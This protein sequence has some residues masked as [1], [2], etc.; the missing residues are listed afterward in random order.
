[1]SLCPV[2]R[3]MIGNRMS[4]SIICIITHN[5]DSLEHG[6]FLVFSV[7]LKNARQWGGEIRY[8]EDFASA[9]KCALDEIH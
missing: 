6:K 5:R 9:S 7:E 4:S 3:L 8:S 2:R 1:M